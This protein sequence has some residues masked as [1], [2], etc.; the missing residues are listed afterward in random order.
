MDGLGA[1]VSGETRPLTGARGA[2]LDEYE[3]AIRDLQRVIA[4]I[5]DD[6]LVFEL[7]PQ[8]PDTDCRSI[9]TVLEHVVRAGFAYPTYLARKRTGDAGLEAPLRSGPVTA[10]AFSTALDAVFA[11]TIDVLAAV[12]ES[13]MK[14]TALEDLVFTPWGQ[15]F[16]YDQLM[17]HAIVHVLRHRRQIERFIRELESRRTL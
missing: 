4:G 13:E 8:E 5:A 16:D 15:R 7:H 3:R 10:S 14:H 11:H 9:A 12:D 2:L 1:G 6:A 17:E